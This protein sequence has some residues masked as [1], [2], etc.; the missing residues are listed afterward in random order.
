M[1]IAVITK[2]KDQIKL[3]LYDE[4]LKELDKKEFEDIYT[5]NFF[6]QTIPKQ[7]N[8]NKTLI[9]LDNT[10]TY[11]TKNNNIVEYKKKEMVDDNLT[12]RDQDTDNIKLILANDDN[13]IFIDE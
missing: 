3:K 11:N 9:I 7:Y 1:N 5:L 6:L 12:I 13:S 10:Q 4:N 8:E 2:Y